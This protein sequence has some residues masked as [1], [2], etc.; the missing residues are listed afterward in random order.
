MS[1]CWET[2]RWE[3]KYNESCDMIVQEKIKGLVIELTTTI[4]EN[5]F[6]V[7]KGNLAGK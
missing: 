3:P 1:T 5:R 7:L 6:A 2:S 4:G